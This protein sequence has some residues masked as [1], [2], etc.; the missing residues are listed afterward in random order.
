MANRAAH[1]LPSQSVSPS[2]SSLHMRGGLGK[3]LLIAFLLLAIGP[4][5]F[6]AFVTYHQVQRDVQ[7]RLL[8]SLETVV[9]LQEAHL[10]DWVEAK[11]R[12]L[13][14]VAAA[15]DRSS[16]ALPGREAQV[17]TGDPQAATALQAELEAESLA[18]QPATR[19]LVLVDVATGRV[20]ATTDPKLSAW[21][22]GSGGQSEGQIAP[23][24]L[25]PELMV[26][27]IKGGSLQVPG[28]AEP[29]VRYVWDGKILLGLLSWDALHEVIAE[30]GL[31]DEGIDVHLVTA[32]GLIVSASDRQPALLPARESLAATAETAGEPGED[33]IDGV[34]VQALLQRRIGAGA[35]QDLKGV[36]VF[37]AY[38]WVPELQL[39]ILAEQAQERSLSGGDAVTALIVGATLAVALLTAAIAAVVTR[40]ITRPIVQLT[41]TASWMARGDLSRRV[42]V[43]RRDEIGVLAGAFNRMAAELQILYGNLE[44]RVAERTA[45]LAEANEQARYHARQLAISAEV[46]R[47]A[48]SIRDLP[49]LLG[50]VV[51]LIG[52]SFELDQVSIYLLRRMVLPAEVGTASAGS[53]G[54]STAGAF[55]APLPSQPLA[56][57]QAGSN[58]RLTIQGS[59]ACCVPALVEAALAAGTGGP[60]A[61]TER[62]VASSRA[63][64]FAEPEEQLPAP[65]SSPA[66]RPATPPQMAIPLQVCGRTLGVLHVTGNST[67]S[68]D[69]GDPVIYRSLADQIAIA[70]ENAS[71]YAL[72]HETVRHLR[73]LDRIQSRFLTNMSHAL[74]TPLNSIIGFSR[75]MLKGLDGSLNDL[76]RSDLATIHEGGRQL[77]GLIDDLLELSQ[78]DI[79]PFDADQAL[80]QGE[81][82]EPVLRRTAEPVRGE[83]ELPVRGEGELPVRGEGEVRVLSEGEV[84]LAEIVEGVMATARALAR[85]KP[86]QLYHEVPG[87][88]PSITTDGR[89]L[90]RLILAL[91]ANAIKFTGEGQIRL[92]VTAS[93]DSVTITVSATGQESEFAESAGTAVLQAGNILAGGR[94]GEDGQS[95]SPLHSWTRQAQMAIGQRIVEK[96]GGQMWAGSSRREGT[97]AQGGQEDDGTTITFS[98]PITRGATGLSAANSA[99]AQ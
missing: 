7:Q 93:G 98:L 91:L 34:G 18:L 17:F 96:L 40:R 66:G 8:A 5:S 86:V 97:G 63:R 56:V 10:V 68:F 51:E 92:V 78:W 2:L 55:S 38:R 15:L 84:D 77:L 67:R 29:A 61:I 3:T 32:D 52:R 22:A 94:P 19:A 30:P 16:A 69:K 45:Q 4:L 57:W 50:T 31:A 9:S 6:L 82:R 64:G 95:G 60:E 71:A 48:S 35:Y 28:A 25:G 24:L 37:G 42:A 41:A 65:G 39:G 11:H 90:R 72:E 21:P 36:P 49:A 75:V 26:T 58:G 1:D 53:D 76:Q 13:A 87:D 99:E 14:L 81:S 33:Q 47:V 27:S 54:Q 12:D 85:G 73:D 70:I 43:T 62:G 44:A 74:R 80:P 59:H 89:L 88:V 83:G 79:A 23:Q 46:A 20:L